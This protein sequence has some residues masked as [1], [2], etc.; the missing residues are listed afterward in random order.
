MRSLRRVLLDGGDLS[1][2][3]RIEIEQWLEH[4]PDTDIAARLAERYPFLV[5]AADRSEAR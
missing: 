5:R 4:H 3:E 2:E 1:A